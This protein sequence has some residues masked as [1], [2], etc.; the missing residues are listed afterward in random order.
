M[1][2]TDPLFREFK[3]LYFKVEPRMIDRLSTEV[4]F[5]SASVK[6]FSSSAILKEV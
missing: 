5:I 6:I 4:I 1:T 2:H 3:W